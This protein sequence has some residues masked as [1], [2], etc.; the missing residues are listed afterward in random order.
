[1]DAESEL[2]PRVLRALRAQLGCHVRL[3]REFFFCAA[4]NPPLPT[5]HGILPRSLRFL[6][7]VPIY[8]ADKALQ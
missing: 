5:L 8:A 6:D 7:A 4:V 2:W 3:C 1:M